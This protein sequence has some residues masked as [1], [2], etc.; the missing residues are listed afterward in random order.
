MHPVT[1]QKLSSVSFRFLRSQF[2][3]SIWRRSLH[4]I[5]SMEALRIRG[6]LLPLGVCLVCRCV[7]VG[8]GWYQPDCQDPWFLSVVLMFLADDAGAHYDGLCGLIVQRITEKEAWYRLY[9]K[10]W[11]NCSHSTNVTVNYMIFLN[12][13]MSCLHYVFFNL[14]FK[15]AFCCGFSHSLV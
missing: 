12:S 11:L 9:Y 5:Q 8:C 13:K 1:P 7:W 15:I 3:A 4:K 2:Y 14:C 6:E 10:F